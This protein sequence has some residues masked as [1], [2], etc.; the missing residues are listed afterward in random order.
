MSSKEKRKIRI[1]IFD[2][3]VI[4]LVLALVVT[5]VLRIY[6]GANK[7]TRQA[8]ASYVMEFECESEYNSLLTYVNSGDAVYFESNGYLLGYLYADENSEH[9]VMYEIIDDIPTFADEAVSTDEK[10]EETTE[11]DVDG[12]DESAVFIPSYDKI[13]IGGALTLNSDAIKVKNGGYYTIGEINVTEGSVINVYTDTV[14]FTLKVI[15]ISVI[16]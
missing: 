1:N 14:E 13:R 15:N 10:S 4:L 11:F 12:V 8:D 7:L 5:L 2:V 6:S 16:D 3:V 9:G